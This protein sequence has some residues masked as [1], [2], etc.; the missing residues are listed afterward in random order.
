MFFIPRCGR[1]TKFHILNDQGTNLAQCS[2]TNEYVCTPCIHASINDYIE[3][4]SA[5]KRPPPPLVPCAVC[6]HGHFWPD[7][8]LKGF[9]DD[10]L[11]TRFKAARDIATINHDRNGSAFLLLL[12]ASERR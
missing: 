4:L 10:F 11:W 2:R 3:D 7:N 1:C 12:A 5:N 8:I 6:S 9:L